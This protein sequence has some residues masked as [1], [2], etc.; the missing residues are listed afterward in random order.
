MNIT[1]TATPARIA[2][3]HEVAAESQ[4]A[5]SELCDTFR[6]EGM[7]NADADTAAWAL[8]V[9]YLRGEFDGTPTSEEEPEEAPATP[10]QLTI[11]RELDAA[12]SD[13]MTALSKTFHTDGMWPIDKWAAASKLWRRYLDGEFDGADPTVTVTLP[14]ALRTILADTDALD[15]LAAVAVTRGALRITGTADQL[16]A[17]THDR[18]WVAADPATAEVRERAAYRRWLRNLEGAGVRL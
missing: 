4:G 11:M 7:G 3:V 9:R 10:E 2:L 15:G 8:W 5:Y 18:L 12:D 13:D 17:L 14:A 6:A 1:D 16:T